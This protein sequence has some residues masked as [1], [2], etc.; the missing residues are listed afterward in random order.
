MRHEF[1]NAYW[2][3]NWGAIRS[4]GQG[5]GTPSTTSWLLD[6]TGEY[7]HEFGYVRWA[8]GGSHTVSAAGGGKIGWYSGNTI[9]WTDVTAEFRLGLQDLDSTQNP[10]RGDGTFDVYR[11]LIP[12]TDSLAVNTWYE[13]T[14]SSGTKTLATGDYVVI[15]MTAIAASSTGRMTL[16]ANNL[17][18]TMSAFPGGTVN[19]GTPTL[20]SL[21]GHHMVAD[22]GTLGW[23]EGV[24]PGVRGNSETFSD[25]TNPDER[26]MLFR[27]PHPIEI[28]SL[29][30]IG[31]IGSTTSIAR[32]RIYETPFATPNALVTATFDGATHLHSTSAIDRYFISPITPLRLYPGLDYCLAI[33]A[34]GAGNTEISTMEAN[35]AAIMSAFFGP[36]LSYVTRNND[37]G[38]FGSQSTIKMISCAMRWSALYTRPGPHGHVGIGMGG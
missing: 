25:S 19:Q 29:M 33:K 17:N 34:T 3:P 37:S 20:T 30:F 16:E 15:A 13:H 35:T 5:S 26:G 31:Q 22:D 1:P 28:D 12:G 2:W 24:M 9:V 21:A 11:S 8:D 10:C 4:Y 38:A 7:Y 18:A 23:I 14:M 6:S 27:V 36:D 32:A